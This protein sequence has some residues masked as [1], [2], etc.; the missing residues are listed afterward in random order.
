MAVFFELFLRDD[1]VIAPAAIGTA[2][3]NQAVAAIQ[4]VRTVM[5]NVKLAFR[6]RQAE[7]ICQNKFHRLPAIMQALRIRKA[8]LA[9]LALDEIRLS[10]LY[11]IVARFDKCKRNVVRFALVVQSLYPRIVARTGAVVVFAAA[12]HLFDLP[13]PQILFNGN[14]AD[15]RCRHDSLMLERQ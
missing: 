10:V 1:F 12:N 8:G 7:S 11:V 15:Q 13:F 6:D 5:R 3:A 14:C 4:A 2:V 9:D